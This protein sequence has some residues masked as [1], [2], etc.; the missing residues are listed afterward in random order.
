[1]ASI[2]LSAQEVVAMVRSSSRQPIVQGK[3]NGKKCYFLIDTGSGISILHKGLDRK[4]NLKSMPINRK[5][6]KLSGLGYSHSGEL[7]I[8]CDPQVHIGNTN[9]KTEYHVFD[10]RNII[11][12]IYQTR[13]VRISG[14]IG[15]DVMRRYEFSVNFGLDQISICKQ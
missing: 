15:A 6:Y 2:P 10:L 11:E 7:T 12:S 4:F 9:L 8:A 5:S 13:G 1:V 3:I 14:I